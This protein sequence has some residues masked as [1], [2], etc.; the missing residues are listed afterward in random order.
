MLYA[1][2]SQPVIVKADSQS[3]FYDITLTNDNNNGDNNGGGDSSGSGSGNGDS[4][5]GKDQT[6][7]GNNGGQTQNTTKT[8]GSATVAPA[9]GQSKSGLSGLLPQTNNLQEGLLLGM[10][11]LILALFSWVIY[12]L[13]AD[14]RRRGLHNEKIN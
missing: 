1:L 12:L 8:P 14:K 7:N 13:V 4:N 9:S 3:G 5:S 6:T 10:G 11:V 2:Q